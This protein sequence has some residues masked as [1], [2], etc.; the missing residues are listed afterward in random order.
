[1][2]I[3]WVLNRYRKV[4]PLRLV[5]SFGVFWLGF[6][7]SRA[8][9]TCQYAAIKETADCTIIVAILI[10][11]LLVIVR[12]VLYECWAKKSNLDSNPFTYLG[13]SNM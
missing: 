6:A 5:F 9:F 13:Q 7:I 4:L 8:V 11:T 10:Q 12:F 1:M 3:K 2:D